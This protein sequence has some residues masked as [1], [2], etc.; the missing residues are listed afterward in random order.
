M[1]FD[2]A[3]Y[4]AARLRLCAD[5]LSHAARIAQP[6]LNEAD[7]RSYSLQIGNA[8][9]EIGTSLLFPIYKC[10]PELDPGLGRGTDASKGVISMADEASRTLTE[11]VNLII[12]RVRTELLEVSKAV[13]DR[14][15]PREAAGFAQRLETV[16]GLVGEVRVPATK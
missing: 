11:S 9:G 14:G 8:M 1:D 6:H 13:Q 5:L 4:C 2:S 15:D 16:L 3:S 7:F 12:E 10:H